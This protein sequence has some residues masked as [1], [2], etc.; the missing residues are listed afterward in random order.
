MIL[1]P[2]STVGKMATHNK[3]A[4][5]RDQDVSLRFTPEALIPLC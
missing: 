2:P 4:G 1:G 5:R 3:A